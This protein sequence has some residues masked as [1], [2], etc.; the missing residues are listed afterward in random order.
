MFGIAKPHSKGSSFNFQFLLGPL[1]KFQ[2]FFWHEVCDNYLEYSKHRVYQPE[3]HGQAAKQSAQFVLNHILYSS[4]KLLAPI[5]PHVTEEL[6]HALFGAKEGK[7][8]HLSA[9]PEPGE[10]DESAIQVL[11]SFHA[12]ISEIRQYKAKNK[13][14]QN[15]EMAKVTITLP[16]PLAKELIPELKAVAKIKEV[17]LKEGE[18]KLEF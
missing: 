15:A 16:E 9:W 4:L 17:E 3:I 18:F 12:V 5:V 10:I 6:Y 14:A 7:S 13:L 1:H 8:I 11:T 2:Q